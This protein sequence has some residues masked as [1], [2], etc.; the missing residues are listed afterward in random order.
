MPERPIVRIPLPC[1]I[2][3]AAAILGHKVG[4][5][6]NHFAHFWVGRGRRTGGSWTQDSEARLA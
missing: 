4:Q 2:L 5:L 1:D 6:V 3:K